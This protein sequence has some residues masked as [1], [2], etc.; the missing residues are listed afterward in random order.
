M[1]FTKRQ[2]VQSLSRQRYVFAGKDNLNLEFKSVL[3]VFIFIFTAT[4]ILK[5]MY[6]EDGILDLLTIYLYR[7]VTDHVRSLDYFQHK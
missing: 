1:R 4:L 5:T 3:I 7:P 2:N 6:V